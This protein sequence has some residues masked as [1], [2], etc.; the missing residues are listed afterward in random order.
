MA[1]RHSSTER[2]M[3]RLS[4]RR[5]APWS[6]LW[7]RNR[8]RRGRRK[9]GRRR[10]A[11]G[12]VLGAAVLALWGAWDLRGARQDLLAART[13]LS[14]AAGNLGNATDAGATTT[15]RRATRHA[16]AR[17]AQAASRVRRSPILRLA[18]VVPGVATQRNGVVRAAEAARDAAR[19]GDALA[20]VA[21][22]EA[23]GITVRSGDVDVRAVRTLAEAVRRAGRDLDALPSTHRDSQWGPLGHATRDLDE[24]LE[25]TASRLTNSAGVMRVAAD[26]L[27][28][29][30][31]QRIFVAVLNNAEMRDQGMV[32]SYAVVDTANGGFN[33]TRSGSVLD[34]EVPRAVSEPALPAGT[35]QIFGSLAPDHLWQSVNATAD[36]R[37]S[38]ALMRSLYREATG[39][40]VDGVVALDVPA[41]SRL[42]AVTGEV[43]VAG[44][45]QPINSDNATK[46]L[47]DDLYHVAPGQSFRDARAGRLEQ[48]AATTGAVLERVR[49]SAVNGTALVR[50]LGDAARGGHAWI[51]T[52]D[53][54]GQVSLERAGLGG[55]PGRVH[56]ER[57]IHISV[58]N[59]TATKLDYF[60]DPQVKV[61]VAV[62]DDGS[63]VVKTTVTLANNAPVPTPSSEQFGPD[64]FVTTVAGLYRG[65]VYFWGPAGADQ[66]DSVEESGLRLNF[67]VAEVPAGSSGAVSFTTVVPRAV[68]SGR[69]LLRFVPQARVRPMAL[70]I[71]VNGVGW[72]VRD[73]TRELEWD[74]TLDLSWQLRRS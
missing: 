17:T 20:A 53:A 11:A 24:L 7:P 73:P 21:Q 30:R 66:L 33:V 8:R 49:A 39:D 54:A 58:Q 50:A 1:P 22:R 45:D 9:T 64:G 29:D 13:E 12:L 68:R 70:H 57:T 6:S 69:L 2:R 25:D 47:L 40:A 71:R 34:I 26:L 55:S 38:G 59:G 43:T 23:E 37:L 4:G 19:I 3:R 67:N 35:Q 63:A 14:A 42:L 18:G 46:V 27:G 31:P 36:T 41:L 60:V 16:V 72:E 48:L 51:S 44:I 52:A 10:L 56:P 28:A 61:D 15:L 62:T 32:L 5:A 65:R 74:R